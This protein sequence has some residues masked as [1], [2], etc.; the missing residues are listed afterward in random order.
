MYAAHPQYGFILMPIGG[1]A[2][3][4]IVPGHAYSQPAQAQPP[5]QMGQ[6]LQFPALET[7]TNYLVKDGNRDQ[8]ADALA[9]LPELVGGNGYDAMAGNPS[10]ESLRALNEFYAMVGADHPPP[11]IRPG[12]EGDGAYAVPRHRVHAKDTY[13]A[14]DE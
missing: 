11:R 3:A 14:N 12:N 8:W 13:K 6:V 9:G 2:P 5:Q 4:P 1:A 7:K 10:P